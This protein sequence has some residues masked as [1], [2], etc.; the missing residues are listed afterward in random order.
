M[1]DWQGK[2]ANPD[3][4][5]LNK[6]WFKTASMG[7]YQPDGS[8]LHTLTEGSSK[9]TAISPTVW[10]VAVIVGLGLAFWSPVIL[11]AMN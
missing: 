2:R 9:S 1:T 3:W 6:L 4:P 11:K 7:R 8:V 10:A 5:P